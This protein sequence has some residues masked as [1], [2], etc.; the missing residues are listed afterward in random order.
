MSSTVE[1]PLPYPERFHAA[2]AFVNKDENSK[3]VFAALDI[4]CIRAY[5]PKGTERVIAV[6]LIFPLMCAFRGL[7]CREIAE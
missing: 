5:G 3:F 7:V 1:C 4:D 2:L 6:L